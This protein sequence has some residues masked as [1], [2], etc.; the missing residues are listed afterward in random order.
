MLGD[1]G[2]A[3]IRPC[4]ALLGLL[5]G[6]LLNELAGEK[7]LDCVEQSEARGQLGRTSGLVLGVAPRGPMRSAWADPNPGP[8]FQEECLFLR[9]VAQGK[10]GVM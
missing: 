8:I 3:A 4:E 2:P 10:D 5:K 9:G 1:C 7:S 6:M